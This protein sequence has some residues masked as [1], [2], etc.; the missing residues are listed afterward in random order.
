MDTDEIETTQADRDF[1]ERILVIAGIDVQPQQAR[2][3]RAALFR[4]YREILRTGADAPEWM[5]KA[6]GIRE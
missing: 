5:E 6:L 1:A 2:M 4:T 3:L